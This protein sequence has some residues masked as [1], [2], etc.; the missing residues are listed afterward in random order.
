MSPWTFYDFLDSR[1]KN[2]IRPWLDSI[3]EKVAAKIDARIIYMR[4]VQVWPEAF[5]SSL[6]GYPKIF[7]LRIV[8]HG[9]QYRPLCCYGPNRG[10]VTI[11]LGAMEKGKLPRRVLD[12]AEA[13][14]LIV[15]ADNTRIEP[16]VFRKSSNAG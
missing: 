11:L 1:G 6:T 7:E 8:S 4:S 2:L 10:D 16:H 5:I 14:R 3:P 13:N 12:N 9:S 15:E